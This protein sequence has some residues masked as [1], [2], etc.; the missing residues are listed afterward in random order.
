VTDTAQLP[1]V[2]GGA[3]TGPAPVSGPGG[4][5]GPKPLVLVAVLVGVAVVAGVVWGLVRSGGGGGVVGTP[6]AAPP[7]TNPLTDGSFSYEVVTGPV[8][9]TDCAGNSYGD[10]QEWFS[11]HPCE[12]VVRGL[13]TVQE[14]QA[15]ALVSVVLVVMPDG[16]QAQQ[17]KA[18]TDTDGTGNVN[19]LVRDGTATLPRAPVVARGAYYSKVEGQQVTIVEADFFDE[20]SDDQLLSEIT[21]DAAR[22]SEHLAAG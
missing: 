12:K 14:G 3:D 21:S 17:L 4:G 13:Y 19:D 5:T 2:D 6:E 11:Q 10:M 9:A 15:R 7:S 20:H 8:K 16:A 18:V 22:L 1:A